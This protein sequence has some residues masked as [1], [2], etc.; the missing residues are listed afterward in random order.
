M[1]T[2]TQHRAN[3][4]NAH[5]S[6][7]PRTET[8]KA[9]SAQNSRTHGLFARKDLVKPEDADL[10]REFCETTYHELAPA[11]ALEESFASQI[12]GAN[13]RLRLCD[14]AEAEL[15]D[16]TEAAD[17]TR[18]SIERARSHALNVVNK[19]LAQ[20]RK[21]QTERVLREQLQLGCLTHV[22]VAEIRGLME[23]HRCFDRGKQ[24]AAGTGAAEAARLTAEIINAVESDCDLGS[25]CETELS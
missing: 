10:Y 22:P 18:R 4:E 23:G 9:T 13:W 2:Q 15:E 24:L 17:K 20:L 8:G 25:F 5:H 3:R 21:L 19:S 14:A 11:G 16:F 7:G 12:I 1:A 6:T